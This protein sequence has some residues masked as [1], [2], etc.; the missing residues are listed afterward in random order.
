[1]SEEL[2]IVKNVATIGAPFI[3]AI[4]DIW[5][6][7]KLQKLYQKGKTEKAIF[8]HSVSN[9]FE[10]Y[11]LRSYEKYSFLSTVVFQ[12]QQ[13]SIDELY[14]P[15]T[16]EAIG[17][18]KTFKI[19]EYKDEFI[20]TYKKVLLTDT[21]GMGKSTILKWLFLSSIQKNKGIPIFIELRRLSEKVKVLDL[22]FNGLNPIDEEFD[23][24]FVL[25]IIKRGDFIF[26]LDGFD[27][28]PS[29]EKEVVTNDLQDFI[30]KASNNFY[31]LT[32]RPESSISSFGDFQN[33]SINPLKLEESFELLRKYDK[34]GAISDKLIAKIEEPSTFENIK[35]FLVNPLLVS[36]LYKAY[37][38]KPNIPYTKRIFYRQVYDAL[39][40]SHDFTKG[41]F[42]RKKYS[43]LDTDKFHMVLRILGFFTFKEEKIE[44]IKD[45]LLSII[46][47][48]KEYCSGIYFKESDFLKDLTATVPLFNKEGEYYSWAHKSI[49]EY[50][51][52]EFICN[53]AKDN[54]KRI[55]T[56]MYKSV[57]KSRFLNVLDLCYDIDYKTFRKTIIYN[58]IS[59]FIDYC[60][61]S[62]K[63]INRGKI[64]DKKIR[65]RQKLH[66]CRDIFF[67]HYNFGEKIIE[68][69]N[70]RGVV[71]LTDC[72]L[73]IGENKYFSVDL[74]DYSNMLFI[75][76]L[77][78][79]GEIFIT[80]HKKDTYFEDIKKFSMLIPVG[81]VVRLSD[82]PKSPIN[83]SEIFDITNQIFGVMVSRSFCSPFCLDLE[84]CKKLQTEI[85]DEIKREKLE[86]FLVDGL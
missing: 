84:K 26:F 78:K 49:Q 83:R 74:L 53:D 71:R 85:E 77:H 62:Y 21:A 41:Y 6:K 59:E 24:D 79:K 12:N 15:L 67:A 61:S 65:E 29:H 76:L 66:F 19:D 69:L 14:L 45:G 54:Q 56:K 4:V 3:K 72:M 52:A 55:L 57:E 11:L 17:K 31:I 30:S 27:E 68:D 37:D 34:R 33:C 20:P 22:I 2:Q 51:T 36:L 16:V 80:K 9:K 42:T 25:T 5:I 46:K 60:N 75:E 8:E 58:L 7:P 44:F 10:E 47:K 40:E 39:Y 23:K 64:S 43:E 86:D 50:F 82:H 35:E 70:L 63:K 18:S 73:P 81:E 38:Y 13:K 1:M 48:S 28:I 32:S